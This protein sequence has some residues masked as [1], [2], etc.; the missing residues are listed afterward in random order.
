MHM[1]YKN[2]VLS[3]L[4][5]CEEAGISNGSTNYALMALVEMTFGKLQDFK[6]NP[7][8]GQCAYLMTP[9]GIREKL[10]LMHPL[11]DL[12]RQDFKGLKAEITMLQERMRL[13]EEMYFSY[14]S[15]DLG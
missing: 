9:K 5:R 14:K 11:I 1:I 2:P 13:I 6:N 3:S 7:R 12:K 4:Q 10:L 8:K 15:K